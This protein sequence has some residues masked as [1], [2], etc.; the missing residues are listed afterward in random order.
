MTN[1]K[2]LDPHLRRSLNRPAPSRGLK[3]SILI[4]VEDDKSA[5]LYF[6]KFR[7]ALRNQRIV[8]I[9]DFLGSAPTSVIAAAKNAVAENEKLVKADAADPFEE[10][11]VVFDTEGPQ[12]SERQKAARHAIDQAHQLK[13]RTAI[14]N[15]CFEYWI[16][17]HFEY[18]VNQ[19]ADGNAA[20]KKVKKYLPRYEKGTCC[21]DDTRPFVEIA[22]SNSERVWRERFQGIEHPCDCHPSTEIHRLI[23]SLIAND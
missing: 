2:K 4:S 22:I 8:V 19:L 16:L 13:Y 5:R 10:V 11:W 12:N 20:K 6:Q 21:Y 23:K 1:R 14:S 7:V 3:K 18:F 17:L 15:P 9:A